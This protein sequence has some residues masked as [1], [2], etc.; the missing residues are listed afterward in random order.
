[1]GKVSADMKRLV[2]D[3]IAEEKRAQN[4][5]E[6][7]EVGKMVC[8]RLDSWKEVDPNTIDMMVE[9]DFRRELDGWKNNQEQLPS[10]STEMASN[11][12]GGEADH[13]INIWE[14]NKDRLQA[15]QQKM[16]DA[17]CLLSK[18]AGRSSCC[19]FSV[20]QSLVD[21]NDQSYQPQIVSIG[22]FH[23]GKPHLQMIEEHKWRFLG[24][25]LSRIQKKGLFLED[26]LKTIQPLEIQV[27]ESYSQTIHFDSHEFIEML[28]LDGCFLIELFRRV[29][30]VVRSDADDPLFSMPWI[31]SFFLRDLIRLENQ[32]P[33]FILQSLFDLTQMPNQENA[34]SLAT[35]ALE[36]F[37]YTL[38]RPDGVITKHSNLQGKHL[39][40]FIRLSFIPP[41][42]EPSQ[43]HTNS[44]PRLIQSISKL[45]R[46]GIK[47]KPG[48]ADSFLVVKFKH[49]VI[50]MPTIAIDDFMS[51]FLL[52]CVAY[53]QCHKSCSKH[54][55]AYVTLLDC[56]INTV[57]D[58]EY[59]SDRSII[60]NYIGAHSDVAK[61]INNMGKDVSFDIGKC[62]LSKLFNDVDEYY[63]NG[64][65][66]HWASFR[67]TYFNTPWSFISA[68][69]ALVL[70]ILTVAQTFFTIIAYVRP[71]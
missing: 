62:Y 1:M 26:L 46:A 31:Y 14:I 29:G 36:F 49:G 8:K 64:W 21:V 47:L 55:T 43:N 6:D 56:L 20:P 22:P 65:H 61:L 30:K 66:L 48:K 58:V 10:Y 4:D 59:L 53:E 28:V 34:K 71:P 60:E 23:H 69:A 39:L 40:D 19:I 27:R 35:L 16:S 57:R 7:S 70:L 17:P 18:S 68:L 67:Y 52:N 32:I 63:R 5:M 11:P 12:A 45:R 50:E 15:M 44:Q 9:L 33:L 41:N 38:Q 37:D 24:A 3:L 13:V 51:S 2:S 54:V 42:Q 25:L